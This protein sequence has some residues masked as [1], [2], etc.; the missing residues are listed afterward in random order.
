MKLNKKQKGLIGAI[1]LWMIFRLFYTPVILG[2]SLLDV[3]ELAKTIGVI[4]F[5]IIL[6]YLVRNGKE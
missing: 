6:A 5:A 4:F 1:V 3:T 2:R